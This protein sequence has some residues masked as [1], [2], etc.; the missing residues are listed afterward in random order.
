MVSLFNQLRTV[1]AAAVVTG[2]M[3]LAA[4]PAHAVFLEADSIETNGVS[5]TIDLWFFEIAVTESQTFQAND[6]GGPPVVGAD[7]DMIIY[8]D[9]GTFSNIVA[10]DNA[11]G[12]DP[13][14]T[15]VFNAGSYVAA[16]GNFQLTAGEIGPFQADTNLAGNYQY[17]FNGPSALD[18]DPILNCVLSGNLDGSYSKRVLGADTC[19]LSVPEPAS[20]GLFGLGFALLGAGTYIRRRYA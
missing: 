11:S 7:P 13:S 18:T 12:S 6:L 8:V 14:I 1:A 5:S 15:M 2:A 16:V 10:T 3:A 20:L 19:R 4:S 17:E 9:D